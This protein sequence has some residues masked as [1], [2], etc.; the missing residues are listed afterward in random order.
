MNL[1][2]GTHLNPL[3]YTIE[4]DFTFQAPTRQYYAFK[5]FTNVYN[6]PVS[7]ISTGTI[8]NIVLYANWD[9]IGS[10][11]VGNPYLIYTKAQYDT[12]PTRISSSYKLMSDLSF[13][14]TYTPIGTEANPFMGT[15]DGNGYQITFTNIADNQYIFALF[16]FTSITTTVKNI[17]VNGYFG[18]VSTRFR[19]SY[20]AGI[21]GKN[22]GTITNATSNITGYF[23]NSSTATLGITVGGIAAENYGTI[24]TSRNLGMLN[25]ATSL[26]RA[27]A[28]GIVG[29][30]DGGFIYEPE[31][32][33]DITV[34]A[35]G[36]AYAGG[37]IGI[38]TNNTHLSSTNADGAI[39]KGKISALNATKRDQ[40]EVLGFEDIPDT[41]PTGV[42]GNRVTGRYYYLT[43]KKNTGFPFYK[44]TSE[45][46]WYLW[47]G[48]EFVGV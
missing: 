3:T 15:F 43:L 36:L 30:S 37:I 41:P 40:N 8:G 2:D 4:S 5:G 24:N 18:T 14:D 44:D 47:N 1:L 23:T 13:T 42:S 20:F 29:F 39:A 27:F 33:G 25:V 48:T 16:G 10:G 11:T 46:G 26:N 32:Q 31:N 35:T 7:S 38:R 45:T 6:I 28:G 17:T 34:S 21:V 22:Y 9:L 12:I 19:A